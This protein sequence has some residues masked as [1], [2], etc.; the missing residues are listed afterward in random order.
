M[1]I[2]K[3]S[4]KYSIKKI[5]K[6]KFRT[7]MTILSIFIGIMIIFILT[8]FGIGLYSFIDT[9]ASGSSADK[10]TITPKGIGAPGLDDT[11]ALTEKDLEAIENT[12]GVEQV[13]G[14]YIKI[15]EIEKDK[16]KKYVFLTG[17]DPKKPIV[18]ELSDIGL[19]EGRWL[20]EGD[21]G[22]IIAG[23]SYMVPD[24]IFTKPYSLNDKIEIHGQEAR[25]IG[26]AE[27]VGNPQDDSQLYATN[28][29]LI[30]LYGSDIKGY[31]WVIAE[32]DVREMKRVIERIEDSLR[33]SRGLEK[34]EEDF[35]VQSWQ[36]MVDTYSSILNGIIG[37]VILI[38]L[39]SIL[40]SAINTTNTMITSV[41]ERYREIGIMKAVGARNSE[42]LKIFLFESAFLGFLAGCIGVFLGWAISSIIALLLE[43][44]GWGFLSPV[45]PMILIFGLILFATLTGALSG[46]IPAYKAS[47]INPVQAL[48]EE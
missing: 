40:V 30:E 35:F 37:F 31:S 14:H 13:T 18:F 1:L 29:Y 26:F 45:F 6:S 34:G 15:T 12:P 25:I 19:I 46:A 22:K 44:L 28:D 33:E 20:R 7:F 17:Y 36:D 16:E 5:V 47:R 43:Q 11:F 3:E 21:R 42:I 2:S 10:I 23:Y 32:V 4:I 8:S 27:E 38:A 24:K 39:V 9:F 48:R 41:L